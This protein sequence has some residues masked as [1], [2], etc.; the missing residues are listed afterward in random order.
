MI[1]RTLEK[2]PDW[3]NWVEDFGL[4]QVGKPFRILPDGLFIC[5][6]LFCDQYKRF[7]DARKQEREIL[8]RE[9]YKRNKKGSRY[10]YASYSADKSR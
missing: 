4:I 3:Q 10:V 6:P 2:I 8:C 7:L 1:R 5:K 9:L